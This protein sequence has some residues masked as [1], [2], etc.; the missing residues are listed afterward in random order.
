MKQGQHQKAFK[1]TEPKDRNQQ[2]DILRGF[3]LFG[4]L[5]VNVFGYN[6][7]F[8]DFSGFYSRFTDP[9][10]ST[11]FQFLI[12]YGA[13][14]FI[15]IFSFLFGVGFAMMYLKY[16]SDEKRFRQ[17]YLRRL[18]ALM[19]FGIIHIVFFWA[20]D[21]LFSYALMGLILLASRKLASPIL[22]WLSVTLYFFPIVY[23]AFGSMIP[24]LPNA[25]SST[26]DIAL[27]QVIETYSHA[28]YIEILNLRLHEYISFRNI[29]LIYYA[30][31][32]LSL[33]LAGYLFQKHQVLRV[34]NKSKSKFLAV[35]LILLAT[36]I[37]LTH[38]TE[39]IV[40]LLARSESNIFYSAIYMAVFE[41]S[42]IFLASS[43]LLL[44]LIL[45][46]Y[47]IPNVVFKPL[48]H[49]GRLALSN[50]MLQSVI[51]TSIMYGYGFGMFASYQPWQLLIMAMV[52]FGMQC[53]LSILY[54]QRF[55]FGPLE[56]IWRKA[57]YFS[58]NRAPKAYIK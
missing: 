3:A 47:P 21:I 13:D 27:P 36:G 14:K 30:P 53:L 17:I 43:Y 15:F 44:V 52:V 9:M 37:S 41:I 24:W 49:V 57:T 16:Q 39:D 51:F 55:T 22:V 2:I 28:G 56:W 40:N 29:N 42:N 50:Y 25:L 58:I 31:K 46:Q 5:L 8:F 19:L 33:F 6:A 1:P 38:F 48:R 18:L 12:A 45:S 26:S 54:L 11:I 35:G 10:N 34:L 7:S 20:G 32:V 4:V 23:I